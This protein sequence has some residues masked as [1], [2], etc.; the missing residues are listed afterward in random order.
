MPEPRIG[1]AGWSLPRP[2]W[3]HFPAEGSHLERYAARFNAVEINSSFY[4]PHRVETYVRWAESVPPEFRF[5]VKLP[6]VITH[7]LRLQQADESLMRF[8]NEVAGLGQKLGCI[9]I[10]LPPSLVFDANVAPAFLDMLR[11]R[12][13]G[14]LALEPRHVSWFS[15]AVEALLAESRIARVLADPVLHPG[16]EVPGGWSGLQ[17]LRLHGS[18]KVYYSAYAP[19]L[20]QRLSERL[21]LAQEQGVETWCIFDNTAAGEAVVNA[22]ELK[23]LVTAAA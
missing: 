10:Q 5:A 16:G 7:E 3:P 18:P 12:H 21:R 1:C 15:P 11:D 9:L 8:L 22:R 4:R 2:E 6:R 13:A 20:L 23:A 19:A 17:Y 14:A